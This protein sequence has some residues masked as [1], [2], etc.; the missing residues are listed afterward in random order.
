M[1]KF[2]RKHQGGKKN[3]Y[4]SGDKGVKECIRAGFSELSW[5]K[6]RGF[7]K[8]AGYEVAQPKMIEMER[9]VVT[10]AAAAVVV[11]SILNG[12]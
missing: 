8:K 4:G 6:M 10:M 3:T 9:Q 2:L 12:V 11:V 5:D 1:K 7:C